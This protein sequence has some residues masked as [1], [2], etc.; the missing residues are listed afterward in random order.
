MKL[1]QRALVCQLVE[2]ALSCCYYERHRR[3]I[4]ILK[5][6]SNFSILMSLVFEIWSQY[7]KRKLRER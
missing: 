4:V 2:P 7:A 1:A 6:V 3:S 5:H